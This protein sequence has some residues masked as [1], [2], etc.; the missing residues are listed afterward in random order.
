MSYQL[1]CYVIVLLSAKSISSL[2]VYPDFTSTDCNPSTKTDNAKP[3]IS[4]AFQSISDGSTLV[5]ME[6]G[7][8]WLDS[9]SI[10]EG[11]S[12]VSIVSFVNVNGSDYS[13]HCSK[14]VGIAFYQVKRLTIAGLTI[15]NCGITSGDVKNFSRKMNETIDTF[16]SLSSEISFAVIM[17]DCADVLVQNLTITNTV[18]LGLVLVNVVGTSS[19][20]GLSLL[21]NWAPIC[22]FTN[23][24]LVGSER[25]IGG[26]MFILYS[27]YHSRDVTPNAT[28]LVEEVYAHNNSFCQ[29]LPLEGTATGNAIAHVMGSAGGIGIALS[30]LDYVVYVTVK[31]ATFRNNTGWVSSGAAITVYSGVKDSM[32][33]FDNCFF[34][35]NGYSDYDYRSFGFIITTRHAGLFILKNADHP[36][37]TVLRESDSK[38]RITNSVFDGN[39]AEN[40]GNIDIVYAQPCLLLSNNGCSIAIVNT[41]ITNNQGSIGPAICASNSGGEVQF[42]EVCLELSNITVY[43]NKV[44]SRYGDQMQFSTADSSGQVVLTSINVNFTV[45]TNFTDNAGVAII[46]VASNLYFSG[47][48]LFHKNSGVYGGAMQLLQQSHVV[49]QNNTRVEFSKNNAVFQGGAIYTADLLAYAMLGNVDCF[50]YFQR[51]DKLCNFSSCPDIS[52]LNISVNFSDNTAY[53]GGTIYGTTLTDCPWYHYSINKN[54]ELKNFTTGLDLLAS[55]TDKFVFKPNL[56]NASVVSTEAAS[57]TVKPAELKHNES[58]T[59]YNTVYPGERLLYK[60]IARD[61]FD[62]R[63]NAIL[64]STS[65]NPSDVNST[66]GDSFYWF[67]HSSDVNGSLVP[68]DIIGKEGSS[69]VIDIF[70][71]TASS[72]TAT[73]NV[74]LRHCGIGFQYDNDSKQCKCENRYSG[75]VKCDLKNQTLT[76]PDNHW[77]GPVP[78]LNNL[79]IYTSCYYDYCKQG[80]RTFKP[81]NID[82]QCNTGYNR[83]GVMCTECI[84]KTSTIFGS[85][86]CWECSD[87]TLFW[88]PVFAVAGVFIIIVIAFL[89]ISVADGCVTGFLFYCNCLNYFLL[90]ILPTPPTSY[91]FL[92]VSWMNLELGIESCFYS[93]MSDLSRF[94]LRLIFP[95]YLYVL[96]FLIVIVARYSTKFGKIPFS[97]SKTFATL[98]LLTFFSLFGTCV[99][100]LGVSKL[101]AKNPVT[102]QVLTYYGWTGDISHPYGHGFHSALIVIAALLMVTFLIPIPLLLLSPSLVNRFRYTYKFKPI[103][104][105]F[106]NAYRPSC[107]FWFGVKSLFRIVAFT[108][109]IYVGYPQNVFLFEISVLV[110]WFIQDRFSPYQS[111]YSN[112]FNS[113]LMLNLVILLSGN[114]FSDHF[115][116]KNDA[117]SS[118]V[119]AFVYIPVLAVYAAFS[120]VIIVHLFKRFPCLQKNLSKLLKRLKRDKSHSTET[121]DQSSSDEENTFDASKYPSSVTFTEFREPLID[122]SVN[123]SRY[124]SLN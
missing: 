108:L 45:S 123:S 31:S 76:V 54:P 102:D 44:H 13:V 35:N 59:D 121:L 77:F 1:I 49:I 16:Y 75:N 2:D 80:S 65:E 86:R 63:T 90:H 43:N 66:L 9:F 58:I 27:D 79:P 55:F 64:L 98:F 92:P 5:L 8:Y 113:F 17:A 93:G 3:N 120:I 21:G 72:W 118:E 46:S 105:A 83:S 119:N 69:S 42:S 82:S 32:V 20:S 24:T 57:L 96:M 88:I 107:R 47:S 15:Y 25:T 50:L 12:N 22:D 99:S 71:T 41:S 36:K 29:T 73:V 84:E 6:P 28:L 61:F 62:F 48:V 7:C 19:F 10:I 53:V 111:F 68:V 114:I 117:Q 91:F 74:T 97:P 38:V 33:V 124:N 56:T 78:Q 37:L 11:V 34:L 122:G 4:I 18:G 85:N 106:W 40:C 39:S 52:N 115:T 95:T 23:A 112:S 104:D 60:A 103:L 87:R 110:L 81:Y 30:Q 116:D 89:D 51:I 94:G 26:G 100:L 70:A 67:I 109:A 101:Q 14:S